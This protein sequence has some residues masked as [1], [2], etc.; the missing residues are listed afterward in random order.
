MQW[1]AEFGVYFAIEGSH[2]LAAARSLGFPSRSTSEPRQG[3]L[4]ADYRLRVRARIRV[5]RSDG[6]PKLF[7]DESEGR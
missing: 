4:D 5:N 7:Q 1:S 6:K 2:R 3:A